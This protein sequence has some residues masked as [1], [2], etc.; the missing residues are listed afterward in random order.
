[1]VNGKRYRQLLADNTVSD[2]AQEEKEK[3]EEEE[4]DK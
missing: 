2:L 3:E 1:M 4:D